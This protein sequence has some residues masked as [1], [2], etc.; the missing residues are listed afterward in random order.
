MS[1]RSVWSSQGTDVSCAEG[2]GSEPGA[3]VDFS[4]A[5]HWARAS[6]YHMA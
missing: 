1:R 6:V 2:G 5:S 3:L 4:L